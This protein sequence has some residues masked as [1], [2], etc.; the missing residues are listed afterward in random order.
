MLMDFIWKIWDLYTGIFNALGAAT[1]RYGA[2]EN[3]VT[4]IGS[5]L[6]AALVIGFVVSLF[7]KGAR[8][9]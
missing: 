8:A 1:F 2:G 6:F 4:S 7:W 5:V 3:D 9:Q